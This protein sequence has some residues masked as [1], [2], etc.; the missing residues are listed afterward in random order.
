MSD[1]FNVT[2]TV[3][4]CPTSTLPGIPITDIRSGSGSEGGAGLTVTANRRTPQPCWS[5][6]ETPPDAEMSLM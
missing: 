3:N 1:L 5:V 4:G 6:S 2:V